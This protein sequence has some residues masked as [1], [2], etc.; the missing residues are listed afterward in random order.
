MANNNEKVEITKTELRALIFWA[1]SGIKNM[2]GGSYQ[3][4]LDYIKENYMIMPKYL[5][6]ECKKLEF[7]TRL[8]SK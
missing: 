7:G 8:K 4:A 3:M 1:A 6:T 2:R 5:Q